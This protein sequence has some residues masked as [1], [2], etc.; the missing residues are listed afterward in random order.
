MAT[1]FDPNS[2]KVP[3]KAPAPPIPPK[4]DVTTT[5]FLRGVID[6]PHF[7]LVIICFIALFFT[8]VVSVLIYTRLRSTSTDSISAETEQNYTTLIKY[9]DTLETV[10][11]E[12]DQL[13][14]R[15]LRE[16]KWSDAVRDSLHDEMVELQRDFDLHRAGVAMLVGSRC[17]AVLRKR[18]SVFAEVV[19]G[20]LER[21]SAPP[22]TETKGS[23]SKSKAE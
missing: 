19:D 1:G 21:S 14:R 23:G 5:D 20:V 16:G 6:S 2:F 12:Q 9:I 15:Q 11:C 13:L 7:N 17:A 4:P 8:T 3:P 10:R 18:T 22:V